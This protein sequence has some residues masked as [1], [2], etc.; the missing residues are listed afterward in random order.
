MDTVKASLTTNGYDPVSVAASQQ[1]SRPGKRKEPETW[2][3]SCSS[4]FHPINPSSS[5][6]SVCSFACTSQ[7]L[8]AAW[9]DYTRAVTEHDNPD[10]AE[11]VVA[12]AKA[13]SAAASKAP[14]L[15][16][17][18]ALPSS[19]KAELAA[20]DKAIQSKIDA[21]DLKEQ[22]IQAVR[23]ELSTALQEK[24][25]SFTSIIEGAKAQGMCMHMCLH[26]CFTIHT[27][28]CVPTSGLRSCRSTAGRA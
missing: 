10:P 6:L 26:Q 24:K 11:I 14:A 20:K 16:A 8:L 1:S 2:N 25:E 18:T 9:K 23:T 7:A 19:V 15:S 3:V 27:F 22:E 17:P 13:S 5:V 28:I 4:T 21:L 12:A